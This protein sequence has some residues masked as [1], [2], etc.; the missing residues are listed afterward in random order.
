LSFISLS[1]PYQNNDSS[2]RLATRF[3]KESPSASSDVSGVAIPSQPGWRITGKPNLTSCRSDRSRQLATQCCS[4]WQ[5]SSA[6]STERRRGHWPVRTD[7]SALLAGIGASPRPKDA[8]L[9]AHTCLIFL[10]RVCQPKY[11]SF[12]FNPGKSLRLGQLWGQHS[13]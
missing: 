9:M 10:F 4:Q 6:T 2:G 13:I 5:H 7:G 8:R 1:D 12:S 11:E 3:L